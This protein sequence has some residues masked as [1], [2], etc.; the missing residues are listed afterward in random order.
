VRCR[1]G[2]RR[3]GLSLQHSVSKVMNFKAG[4]QARTDCEVVPQY[5]VRTPDCFVFWQPH[6]L[7]FVFRRWLHA[8]PSVG[9]G[10]DQQY[11]SGSHLRS[12]QVG[13]NWSQHQYVQ[14][15]VSIEDWW[16][17]SSCHKGH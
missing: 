6:Y 1:S 17:G 5:L 16:S 7:E 14:L 13:G 11:A 10:L 8:R 3:G 9:W 12:S 15:F 4:F 2:R